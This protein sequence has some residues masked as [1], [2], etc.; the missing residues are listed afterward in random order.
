V[1]YRR[2]QSQY[3]RPQGRIKWNRVTVEEIWWHLLGVCPLYTHNE[4]LDEKG[5]NNPINRYR[6]HF[7]KMQH[8]DG[9]NL[10]K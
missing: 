1:S 10:A 4:W 3:H 6:E 5:L 8:T 9:E 7:C 2:K